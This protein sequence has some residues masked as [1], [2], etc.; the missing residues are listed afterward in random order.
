ML[1]KSFKNWRVL[2]LVKINTDTRAT[3]KEIYLPMKETIET[4]EYFLSSTVVSKMDYSLE[5]EL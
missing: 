4:H 1:E 3:R 2:P 5:F